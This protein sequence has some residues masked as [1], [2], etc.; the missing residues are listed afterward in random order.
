M[1]HGNAQ[2]D[3]NLLVELIARGD[4]TYEQIG[5][6]VGLSA[7]CVGRVARGESR[8]ELQP[9]IDAVTKAY[10]ESAR[11]L[12]RRL[13]HE[14]MTTLANLMNDPKQP[15]QVRRACALDILNH[16]LGDPSRPQVSVTQSQAVL[17]G[18]T[19]ER[20]R[21]LARLEG[22]PDDDDADEDEF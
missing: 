10:A 1:G 17:P 5:R 11:R 22:G 18:L 19:R 21:A 9:R 16:A 7:S 4:M 6:E 2:Y 8:P 14:A 13:A 12:G 3:D 20:A 15:A